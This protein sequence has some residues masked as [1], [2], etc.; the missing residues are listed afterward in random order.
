MARESNVQK[1][2]IANSDRPVSYYDLDVIVSVGYRVKSQPGVEFR[3]RATQVLRRYIQP[4]KP[5]NPR[6][7]PLSG[8]L[9]LD[10]AIYG[11]RVR[12][13]LRIVSNRASVRGCSSTCT[14]RPT[15]RSL[16]S[17]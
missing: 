5:E 2:H 17:A 4:V 12:V 3:R 16:L 14:G 9:V 13:R 15:T 8:R 6:M 11:F 10:L 7:G 1:E